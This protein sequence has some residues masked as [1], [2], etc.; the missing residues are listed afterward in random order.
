MRGTLWQ[1]GSG[2]WASP[3]I[4]LPVADPREDD[5]CREAARAQRLTWANHYLRQWTDLQMT[6][7][8]RYAKLG[9]FG[10][11]GAASPVANFRNCWPSIRTPIF[12]CRCSTCPMIRASDKP[13]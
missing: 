13:I 5:A 8:D 1:L 4:A 11:L 6:F 10:R 2:D 3:D 12:P 9:Q 7:F